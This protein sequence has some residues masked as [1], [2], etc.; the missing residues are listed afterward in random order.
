MD[1]NGWERK[2]EHKKQEQNVTLNPIQVRIRTSPRIPFNIF[3]CPPGEFSSK[4][5][6]SKCTEVVY[7]DHV[8]RSWWDQRGDLWSNV[9]S[10]CSD[11]QSL[12]A[13]ADVLAVSMFVS[14]LPEYGDCNT[15][16]T[17]CTYT[18]QEHKHKCKLINAELVIV[19]WPKNL[20]HL[21]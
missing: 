6:N 5:L 8:T 16:S 11:P 2:D 12:L 18:G 14:T 17:Y 13:S 21:G 19:P 3:L 15:D 1:G 4:Y 7:E 10:T 9:K 20:V